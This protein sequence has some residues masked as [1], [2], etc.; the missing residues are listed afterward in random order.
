[1]SKQKVNK[2]QRIKKALLQTGQKPPHCY[3]FCQCNTACEL[4]AWAWPCYYETLGQVAML[5]TM[6]RAQLAAL[7]A[8]EVGA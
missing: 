7:D 3:R 8:A 6:D 2:A 1:M 4:C 5:D